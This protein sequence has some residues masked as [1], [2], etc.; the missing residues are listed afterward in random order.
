MQNAQWIPEQRDELVQSHLDRVSRSFAYGI[1]R[2]DQG[3]RFSVG[4]SYL[5]CRLLDTVEDANWSNPSDQERAFAKFDSF[6]NRLPQ[7]REVEE[8]E[9]SFPQ[10]I[11]ETEKELLRDAHSVFIEFHSL[12]LEERQAIL[13]PVL[14]MSA[15]MRHFMLRKAKTGILKLQSLGEVNRYCFFVAGVV[16][17]TLTRL[18]QARSKLENNGLLGNV[19]AVS[20]KDAIRF[21]LFLQKVN[22]LKDQREDEKSGRFLVP[23]RDSV[24]ASAKLDAE[25]AFAYLR[26]IPVG[27]KEYRLFCGWALF[28]GLASLP[29]IQA[30]WNKEAPAKISRVEALMLAQKV[31]WSISDPAKLDHLFQRLLSEAFSGSSLQIDRDNSAADE[32]E[33]VLSLYRGEVDPQTLVE[34]FGS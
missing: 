33:C 17:E 22:V 2:L 9:K 21:G 25:R 27:F 14:S 28:L 1:A 6:M 26:S 19:K 4:L 15:G 10:S 31:E 24:F 18:L 8:W 32:L 13:N 7:S 29:A 3:L 23:F 34:I 11:P 5:I 20:L 12:P 16:G 30:G